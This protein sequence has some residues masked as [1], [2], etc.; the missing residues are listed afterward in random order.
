MALAA[1]APLSSAQLPE[2]LEGSR[3][4]LLRV[5][6]DVTPASQ[7]VPRL[8]QARYDVTVRDLSGDEPGKQAV[9]HFVYLD[10]FVNETVSEGWVAFLGSSYFVMRSGETTTSF[11][12]VQAPATV[13][14]VYFRANIVARLESSAGSR[15]SDNTEVVAR[16]LPFSFITADIAVAPPTVGPF[17]DVTFPITIENVGLY[18]DTVLLEATGPEG[19]FVSTQPRLTLWPGEKR[20]VGVHVVTPATR[21]FVPTETGIITVK[22]RSISDPTIY[23]RNTV[24]TLQGFFLP[25]YWFPILVLGAVLGV[26]VGKRASDARRRTAKEQGQPE[27]AELTPAQALLLADLK[28]SDP[29]RWRAI[30]NKQ[31][32]VHA[33]RERAFLSVRTRREKLEMAIVEKQHAEVRAAK[34]AEAARLREESERER[35]VERKR[36]ELER[37]KAREAAQRAAEEKRAAQRLAAEMARRAREEGPARRREEREKR[38][39]E[40][41]LRAELAKRQRLRA[42]EERKHRIETERRLRLLERKRREMERRAKRGAPKK[43]RRG[44]GGAGDEG[45]AGPP[46][47]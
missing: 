40:R 25:D 27:R 33:A 3:A 38:A 8:G 6:V 13:K 17:E 30:T 34:A 26:A 46:P 42:V 4:N 22:A 31:A 47:P 43:V 9:A 39:R 10:L 32:K 15:V 20:D 11:V 35:E 24:I 44:R 5:S 12:V 18:P 29:Q 45:Q 19:W 28:K 37:L 36:S 41:K 14:S 2:P 23:E 1:L 7:E 21:V 16:V